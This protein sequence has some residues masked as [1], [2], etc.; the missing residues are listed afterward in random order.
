MIRL[1]LTN[2]ATGLDNKNVSKQLLAYDKIKEAIITEK[3]KPDQL[4][5]TR[6]L[7]A[8]LGIS[9]T[10]VAAALRRLA[11]E[12]FVDEIQDKGMFVSRVHIED[13]IELYE[14]KMGMEGVA[15]RLC[16]VRKTDQLLTQMEDALLQYER[17]VKQGNYLKAVQRDNEFHGAFIA[18]SKNSRLENYLRIILEQCGR[19][20]TLSASDPTRMENVILPAHR[21][22]FNAI[23]AGEPE[24]AEAAAREHVADVQDFFTRYQL[25]HHYALK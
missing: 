18:G 4:L 13:F 23:A 14:I 8:E 12:G 20:V 15:A 19:A 21:K 5:P 10:P 25:R 17:E 16:A 2:G 1:D 3:Y 9:R 11:Y 7:S 22:I 6:E 24:P